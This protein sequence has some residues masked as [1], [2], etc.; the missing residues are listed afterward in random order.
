MV[1][2]RLRTLLMRLLVLTLVVACL[3]AAVAG[4]RLYRQ[5]QALLQRV[6]RMQ[7][8]ISGGAGGGLQLGHQMRLDILAGIGRS[9]GKT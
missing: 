6:D 5:G 8:A 7:A 9:G 3:A 1:V 2:R 4:W